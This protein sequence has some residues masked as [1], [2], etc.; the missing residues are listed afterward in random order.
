ML[1][2]I[3]GEGFI[4]IKIIMRACIGL[5]NLKKIITKTVHVLVGIMCSFVNCTELMYKFIAR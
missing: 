1:K 4:Y 3:V 2:T 5:N